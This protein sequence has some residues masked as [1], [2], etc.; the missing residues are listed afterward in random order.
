MALTARNADRHALYEQAVQQPMVIV[1]FIEELFAHAGVRDPLVLREDFCGTGQL[2]AL[3]A[4]SAAERRAVAID[5][6]PAVLEYCQAHHRAPLGAGAE[7]LK[8]VRDDVLGCRDK[9]DVLVSLNFSHFIYKT[10]AELARYLAH[11]RRCVR[12]G[13]MMIL[14]AFGG[15]AS[16]TPGSDERNFSNFTYIWEQASFNPLTNEIVCHIHFAFRNGTKLKRAF[17]YH[18]RMWSLPELKELLADA[19]FDQTTVYFESEEGFIDPGPDAPMD[20][21]EAW[22]AYIVAMRS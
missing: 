11:A 10:R 19:G 17:T 21:A 7:R 1:G 12:P 15:P 20:D 5:I 9:A 16:I 4:A 22:V 14:D 6:D 8:L 13:G 18:W 2:A 3:W